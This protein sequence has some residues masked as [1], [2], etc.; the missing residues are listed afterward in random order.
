MTPGGTGQFDV[1]VDD[2][3]VFSKEDV[4]RFPESDEILSRL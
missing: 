3:L 1:F 4:G 2:A